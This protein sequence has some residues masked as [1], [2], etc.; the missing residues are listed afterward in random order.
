M[1]ASC[2]QWPSTAEKQ[3]HVNGVVKPVAALSAGAA[4]LQNETHVANGAGTYD[5]VGFRSFTNAPLTATTSSST[6]T[7]TVADV[8]SVPSSPNAV[9]GERVLYDVNEA[10][11]SST[12]VVERSCL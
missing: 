12:S 10:V 8:R 7:T 3:P 1:R 6:V 11:S 4:A 2:L 9:Y 5:V